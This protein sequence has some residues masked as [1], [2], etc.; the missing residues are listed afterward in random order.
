MISVPKD[1]LCVD[2]ELIRVGFMAPEDVHAFIGKLESYDLCF[3]KDGKALDIVVA[4]QQPGLS[5][6]GSWAE[7][8]HVNTGK[9]KQR[10]AAS[11][12]IGGTLNEAKTPPG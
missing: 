1:T 3:L 9:G 2:T 8:G 7:L 5:T 10:V 11:H 12:L 6:E 4:D